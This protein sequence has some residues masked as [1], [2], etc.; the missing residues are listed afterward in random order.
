MNKL[1]IR[2]YI[3]CVC[4]LLIAP[5]L[6]ATQKTNIQPLD[7]IELVVKDFVTQEQNGAEGIKVQVNSLDTRLRLK[8]CEGD[9]ETYWSPGSRKLGRVTVQVVCSHP[10]PWRIHVQA[11][12]T[13]EGSVW[14]LAKGVKRGEILDR[15]LIVQEIVTVGDNSSTYR[16]VVDPVI[17]LEPW[18]GFEF[19]QRVRSGSVLTES[20]LVPATVISKGEAV[21]ITYKTAGLQ[22]QTKG[23]ALSDGAKGGFVQVKNTSSGKTIDAVVIDRGLVALM[24]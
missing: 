12:A 6:F 13:L 3:A 11:T 21:L 14:V 23:V 4:L 19:S 7:E 20:M 24:Q 10:N 9:L 18:L 8:A 15:S 22:L 2:N 16:N 5:P 1:K 17:G